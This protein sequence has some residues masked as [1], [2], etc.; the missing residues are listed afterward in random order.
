MSSLPASESEGLAALTT[1]ILSEIAAAA[2]LGAL[3]QVRVSSLG[4]KG[5][6][7]LLM[8][9]LG[10]MKPEEGKAFGQAVNSA[11]DSIQAALEARK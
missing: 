4:K 9:R 7:S 6:V 5:R 1:E 11:K 10:G 2:D 8:Q 3:D